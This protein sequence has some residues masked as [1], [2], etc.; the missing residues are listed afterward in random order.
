VIASIQAVE[1]RPSESSFIAECKFFNIPH[2]YDVF[3]YC[4]Q[5]QKLEYGIVLLARDP[6][7]VQVL[8]WHHSL[9]IEI[10]L[11]KFHV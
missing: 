11:I 7:T 10:I 2:I 4:K 1:R 6:S 5:I 8:Q 3:S 9:C